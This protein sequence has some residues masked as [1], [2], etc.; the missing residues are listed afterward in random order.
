MKTDLTKEESEC[1]LQI[2]QHG[3]MDDMFDLAYA[4]GRERV[5][6]EWMEKIDTLNSPL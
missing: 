2:V 6:K 4:I 1:Y 5:A 3:T